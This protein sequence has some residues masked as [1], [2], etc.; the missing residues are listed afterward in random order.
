MWDFASALTLAVS[1]RKYPSQVCVVVVGKTLGGG[2]SVEG[3]GCPALHCHVTIQKTALSRNGFLLAFWFTCLCLV[4]F[5]S[6]LQATTTTT[7]HVCAGRAAK[8]VPGAEHTGLVPSVQE[9]PASCKCAEIALSTGTLQGKIQSSHQSL[10]H[11]EAHVFCLSRPFLLSFA[12]S[13]EDPE[14]V[15]RYSSLQLPL[16]KHEGL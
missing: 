16:G 14:R 9:I 4:W 15:A 3:V 7:V 10:I 2:L 1:Q 13:N 8:Y 11:P 12:G 5:C 6:W